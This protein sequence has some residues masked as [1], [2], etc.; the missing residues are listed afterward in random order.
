MRH[1]RLPL[2]VLRHGTLPLPTLHVLVQQHPAVVKVRRHWG[3]YQR[4]PKW[5]SG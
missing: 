3:A 4:M 2:W 1:D 5:V